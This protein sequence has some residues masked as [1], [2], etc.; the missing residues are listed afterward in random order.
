VRTHCLKVFGRVHRGINDLSKFQERVWGRHLGYGLEEAPAS[1]SF[2][3]V[4]KLFGW[5]LS[6]R[7]GCA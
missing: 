2:A 4:N 7:K 6:H 1:I 3:I 5:E